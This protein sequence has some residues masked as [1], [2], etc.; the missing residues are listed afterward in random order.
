MPLDTIAIA[1]ISALFGAG[2]ISAIARARGQNRTDATTAL[3]TGQVAFNQ[4]LAKRVNDLESALDKRDAAD[5]I[6]D[7]QYDKMIEINARLGATLQIKDAQLEIKDNQIAT[8]INTITKMGLEL[9][10]L[11]RDNR[12]LSARVATLERQIE[13]GTMSHPKRR[14]GD[15]AARTRRRLF[16]LIVGIILLTIAF[17]IQSLA[18]G[19]LGLILLGAIQ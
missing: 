2:G 15:Q 10:E 1:I 19:G 8:Q 3:N 9:E 18:V 17:L 4:Q 14:R 13:G 6:R 5:E 12:Q 7:A 11:K 16:W